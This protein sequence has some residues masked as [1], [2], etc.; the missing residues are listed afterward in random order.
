[1]G[2]TIVDV[3]VETKLASSKREARTFIESGAISVGG[4]K[5]LDS[6][7]VLGDEL[8]T[9]GLALLRRGKKQVHVLKI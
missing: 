8:F 2:T 3:L 9:G 7:E 6:N 5:F 4:K 1:V